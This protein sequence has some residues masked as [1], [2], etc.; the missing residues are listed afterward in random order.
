MM[1][2]AFVHASPSHIDLGAFGFRLSQALG[3]WVLAGLVSC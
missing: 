1:M 2:V 3:F